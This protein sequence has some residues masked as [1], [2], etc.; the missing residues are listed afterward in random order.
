MEAFDQGFWNYLQTKRM[1][2]LDVA[3]IGL[4]F[5]ASLPFLIAMVGA[6]AGLL[7]IRRRYRSAGL[8]LAAFLGAMFLSWAM[9]H[10]IFRERPEPARQPLEERPSTS[11]FPSSETLLATAAYLMMAL[12]GGA[13][14]PPGRRRHWLLGGSIAVSALIGVARAFNGLCYP[15]D[16]AAGW[17]A[18][19]ACAL[20]AYWIEQRGRQNPSPA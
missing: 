6:G 8:A 19:L 7:C 3:T 9:G 10:A 12:V 2:W 16:V 20:L 4:S 14:L 13:E 17:A 15:T 11:S 18:G 5:L 1:P